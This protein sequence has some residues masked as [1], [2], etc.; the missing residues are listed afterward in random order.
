MATLIADQRRRGIAEL[1]RLRHRYAARGVEL[2]TCVADGIAAEAIVATATRL[3]SD[4]I[5]IAT[6][7]RTGLSH[8]LLGS[9]AERVVR[10][11]PCPVLTVR[12]ATPVPRRST[13]RRSTPARR[14]A[15]RRRPR[16]VA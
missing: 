4:L 2:T 1:H 3:K 9:V 11:A 16:V 5:V 12:A 13:A 14:G 15:T 6:H 7:G 10:A 8:L